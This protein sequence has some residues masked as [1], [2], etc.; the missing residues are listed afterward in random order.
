MKK[1]FLAA[2]AAT[3]LFAACN[4][5]TVNVPEAGTTQLT[6]K[7][8]GV[9]KS[10]SRAVEAP[11]TDA[12]GTIQLED[13]YIF[14]INP[15]GEV[16][17]SSE[18]LDLVAATSAAG[19]TLASSVASDSRVFVIGNIPS[20]VTVASLT[21]LDEI[22]AA[23]SDIT[24]QADYTKA[25]LANINSAPVAITLGATS[26]V[27]DVVINPLFSRIEL[28][29]I[30]G[31]SDDTGTITAFTV[32]GV[33][34]DDYFPE[35]TFAGGNDGTM[36]EQDQSTTFAGI[37]NTG[38]WAADGAPLAAVAGA[39]L[40]WAHNVASGGLPRFIIKL[41]G[42]KYNPTG[43]G[44]EVT[45]EVPHYL[46]ITGYD[47][48]DEFVRGNIYRIGAE[49]AFTF[50][51]EDLGLTPNP[52]DVPLIVKVRILEWVLAELTPQL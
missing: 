24:L 39:N 36:F 32:T 1:L 7:I 2:L 18:A 33:F 11:G 23:T 43:G 20:D 5:E 49:N 17:D 30:Q 27:A 16:E 38:S 42:V 51:P 9:A 50:G 31:G 52:I 34:L 21:T 25:T 6:I 14:V 46:T 35:F 37:G 48:V 10:V 44:A 40:V 12:P 26:A 47:G 45:L 41:T 3:T 8:K 19:Q 22:L 13:G 28:H 15:L 29:K 4:K